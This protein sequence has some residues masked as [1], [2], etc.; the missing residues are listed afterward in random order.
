MGIV[1]RKRKE[2]EPGEAGSGLEI[3]LELRSCPTCRRDLHPWELTCPID[4]SEPVPRK[5]VTRD[6]PPPPA[7]LLDDE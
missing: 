4:G 3:E 2:E 5:L 1:E 6:L 7:H